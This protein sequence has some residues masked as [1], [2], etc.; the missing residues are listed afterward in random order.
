MQIAFIPSD[1]SF[2]NNIMFD[3][4]YGRDNVLEPFVGLKKSLEKNKIKINTYDLYKNLEGIDIIILSRFEHNYSIISRIIKKNPYVKIV[5][6]VTEEQNIAPLYIE[7]ILRSKLFDIILTWR[8]DMVDDNLFFK[9]YYPNPIRKFSNS[10]SYG[11]KKYLSIINAFKYHSTS[12]VGDLYGERIKAIKYFAKYSEID[13]YG[14]GW[15]DVQSNMIR[16]VYKGSVESKIETLKKYKYAL[17]FENSNNEIGGICEKIFDVMAAG[18]VPIY[19]GA[20]NVSELIPKDTFI[21]FKDFMDYRKLDDYLKSISVER[22]NQYLSAIKKFLSSEQYLKFTSKGFVESVSQAI[23]YIN[24]KS[25]Q[26]KNI[27]SIKLEFINKMFKYP[28][29]F[30]NSK[31]FCYD[32]LLR[33]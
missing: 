5:F 20:P 27:N 9:Y 11:N 14:I 33:Y 28:N 2:K 7:P 26:K 16:K 29:L 21:D 10:I 22:Y 6:L 12:K 30:W 3:F 24:Q 15:Q 25:S 31:R 4:S 19:W 13:L 8:D 1:P 32:L 18:C 17:A 23:D